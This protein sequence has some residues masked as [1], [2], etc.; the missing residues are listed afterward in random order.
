MASSVALGAFHYPCHE[1][2][3]SFVKSS[4]LWP[5]VK[6]LHSGLLGEGYL[7]D[8]CARH[9]AHLARKQVLSK[10]C[11]QLKSDFESSSFC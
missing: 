11:R 4:P 6:Q 3:T 7:R 8:F 10:G 5:V 1:F 2:F 9:P